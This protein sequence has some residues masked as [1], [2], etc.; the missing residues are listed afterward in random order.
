[1]ATESV[2]DGVAGRDAVTYFQWMRAL[3]DLLAKSNTPPTDPAHREVGDL[4]NALTHEASRARGKGADAAPAAQR[5]DDESEEYG[6]IRDGLLLGLECLGVVQTMAIRRDAYE[7]MG[8]PIPDD[9]EFGDPD[10]GEGTTTMAVAMH[11][12]DI[13]QG[14]RS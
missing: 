9:L 7:H 8:K 1:M 6:W 3:A 4:M 13:M 5:A 14:A 2:R 11:T 12:L 10:D